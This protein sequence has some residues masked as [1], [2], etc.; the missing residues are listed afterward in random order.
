MKEVRLKRYTGSFKDPPF[1]DFIQSPIGLVPKDNG[2]NTRLIFHLSYPRDK[3]GTSINAGIPKS[4]CSVKYPDFEQ[5]IRLCKLAGKSAKAAKSDMSSAFRHLPMSV[6]DFCLL[7][8]M[9]RHPKSK[10]KYY[11]VDKCLPFGSSISCAIFQTFSDAVTFVVTHKTGKDNVNYLDDFLFVAL[12][13]KFCREQVKTFIEICGMI[14][15]P[16][17]LEKNYLGGHHH[18]LSGTANRHRMSSSLCAY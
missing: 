12:L 16:V 1:K 18:H 8:M 11:F 13:K 2:K 4:K 3:L 5:A 7:I 6:K 17:A 15:F 14:N 10:K 9:A